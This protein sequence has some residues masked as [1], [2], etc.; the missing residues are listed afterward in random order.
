MYESTTSPSS[1][2]Y[3]LTNCTNNFDFHCSSKKVN[4]SG[5]LVRAVEH[6]LISLKKGEVLEGFNVIR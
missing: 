6:I 5:E 3:I 2:C 4:V 1:V